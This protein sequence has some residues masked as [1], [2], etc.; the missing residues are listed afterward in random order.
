[1][2]LL[3][4]I[5]L[6]L[7]PGVG[8]VN[9]RT[10][11]SYCG[12]EE[13]VFKTKNTALVKIPGIGLKV[14]SAIHDPSF[15]KRAEEE[16]EFINKFKIDSLFFTS[17][18]YPK[19]LK[20]CSDAPLLL[21][22]KGNCDFNRQKVINIVGTRKATEYGKEITR[23]FI[24]GIQHHQP[25]IVS[26]LA[27]GIDIIAHKEALKQNLSTVGVLAHGLDKIYPAI[28]RPIAQ[29][30]LEQGALI[31]EFVSRSKPD[32]ENFPKR[33]RIVAGMCDATIVIEAGESGGALITA[34]IANS[35]NRD[36]FAFPGRVFD[37]FS[38]GCN[39]LIKS[40]G[41]QLITGAKDFEFFMGW[42]QNKIKKISQKEL[43]YE[44]NTDEK[45]IFDI[46]KSENL[47]SI[48]D[49]LLKSQYSSGNISKIL[50]NLEVNAIIKQYP[51]KIYSIFDC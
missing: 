22:S 41:A 23:Q 32:R 42:A 37:E 10:L 34:D 36:V 39:Q 11:L 40:S 45:V 15:F 19:R 38:V 3:H 8:S 35:Y 47:I 18:N 33:N 50:L 24:E 17:P 13:E 48:D 31:T 30:M 44:L 29:K 27:Y 25:I 12:S 46:I 9:G 16:L 4:Q 5:A 6:T 28:H 2:S 49:L 26:G 51:G 14:A 21:Y 20:N 1:M 7:I 43:F